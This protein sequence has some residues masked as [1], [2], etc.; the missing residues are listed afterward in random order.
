MVAVAVAV[1]D[2]RHPNKLTRSPLLTL[3][4]MLG[5]PSTF[6]MRFSSGQSIPHLVTQ[7]EGQKRV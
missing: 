1:Q 6:Y 5:L 4:P 2:L 7:M 3:N